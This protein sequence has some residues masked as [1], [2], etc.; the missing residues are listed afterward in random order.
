MNAVSRRTIAQGLI[1]GGIGFGTVVLVFA[2]ANILAGRS[3]FYTSA[4]LGTALFTEITD[5]AL[6]T[7]T[8]STVLAYNGVHLMAYLAFGVVA[9]ALAS[10]ADRGQQLWYVSLF[11]YLFVSFHLY[12]AVQAFAVPMRPALSDTA[13]WVAGG[14]ASVAMAAYLL[15]K[16]P[17][18][19][20][21]QSW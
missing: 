11:F 4:L 17:R 8:P 14:A 3:P 10:L 7:V 9:A 16:H 12:G 20:A 6:V 19:R 21:R 5:P 1:A 13:I 2:I 15:W 18:M